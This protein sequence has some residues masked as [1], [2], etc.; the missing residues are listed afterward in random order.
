MSLFKNEFPVLGS[1]TA[2]DMSD[3]SL[4]TITRKVQVINIE[5]QQ[6]LAAASAT[7]GTIFCVPKSLTKDGQYRVYKVIVTAAVAGGAAAALDIVKATDGTAISAGTTILTATVN[8]NTITAN[9]AT[10]ASIVTDNSNQLNAGQRIGYKLSGTLTGLADCC[11]TVI[12]E[13]V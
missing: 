10:E 11:V 3:S 8:L 13:R 5:T 2:V 7:S 1:T 6:S 9:T 12:L 4:S